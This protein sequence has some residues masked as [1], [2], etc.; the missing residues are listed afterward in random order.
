MA[1]PSPFERSRPMGPVRTLRSHLLQC[2]STYPVRVLLAMMMIFSSTFLWAQD[3]GTWMPKNNLN[4][5]RSGHTAT[6]LANGKVLLVGGKDA[7]GLAMA[8]AELFDPATGMYQQIAANMPVPVSGHTATLLK[9]GNVLIAGGRAESGAPIPYA[10]VFDAA[11]NTFTGP[12]MLYV[13]R[14]DHTAT[15]LKD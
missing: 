11:I 2:A 3:P 1:R 5:A 13:P 8:T 4:K 6:W 14:S 7:N 10:Q 9:N 12:K 15:V